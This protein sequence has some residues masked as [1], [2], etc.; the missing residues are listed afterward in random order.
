VSFTEVL[1]EIRDT[2]PGLPVRIHGDGYVVVHYPRYTKR[3]GDYA[4]QLSRQ[5]MDDL[6]RSLIED[7]QILEFDETAARRSKRE[8]AIALPREPQPKLSAVLDD[9]LTIIELRLDRYKAANG[10]GQ[11]LLNVDKKIS[12]PGLRSD[13]RQYPDIEAIQKL[14]ATQQ[15]LLA[16]TQRQDLKKIQ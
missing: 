4:L 6:I 3:A 5:E 10:N 8:A 14:A 7:K 1:G 16:L 11:E 13:A 2:D 12:W 15:A 9:S